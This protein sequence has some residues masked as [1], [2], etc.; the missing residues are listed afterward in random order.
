MSLAR[1]R[2]REKERQPARRECGVY[3]REAGGGANKREPCFVSFGS[4]FAP[5][6]VRHETQRR[7][8]RT[9]RW[10]TRWKKTKKTN[11]GMGHV[12]IV[13][14]YSATTCEPAVNPPSRIPSF[15]PSFLTRFFLLRLPPFSPSSLPSPSTPFLSCSLVKPRLAPLC[16]SISSSSPHVPSSFPSSPAHHPLSAKSSNSGPGIR[17]SAPAKLNPP[18]PAESSASVASLSRV[19]LLPCFSSHLRST[20]PRGPSFKAFKFHPWNQDIRFFQIEFAF[21]GPAPS[22][23][24]SLSRFHHAFG[25][26]P[27]FFLPPTIRAV[28]KPGSRENPLFAEILAG[29]N[30][31]KNP[32]ARCENGATLFDTSLPLLGVEFAT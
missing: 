15:L 24:R 17:I 25:F 23:G 9:R 2:G 1:E 30:L 28:S 12:E 16:V 7:V 29:N 3:A 10:C 19:F 31:A 6:F 4:G 20:L 32:C 22:P 18:R 11:G 13:L 14:P 26:A 27:L 5:A 8:E 21:P